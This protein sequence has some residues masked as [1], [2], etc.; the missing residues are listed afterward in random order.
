MDSFKHVYYLSNELQQ[1]ESDE[2]PTTQIFKTYIN[3]KLTWTKYIR[4]NLNQILKEEIKR[5]SRCR[6]GY[7]F[8][9]IRDHQS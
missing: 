6:K 9:V 5:I 2:N 7:Q 8:Y 1:N 4:K 3:T